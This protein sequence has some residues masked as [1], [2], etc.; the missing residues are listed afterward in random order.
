MPWKL[1]RLLLLVCG[2]LLAV[3]EPSSGQ[4]ANAEP[5]KVVMYATDWCPY[6]AKA[7]AHFRKHGIDYV[8]HDIEKSREGR[9]EYQRLGGRGVPLI[10]IG[11]Q[12]MS[13]FSEARFDSLYE[14][15]RR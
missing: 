11:E 7:R 3:A 2:V 1:A 10:L 8:E 13:G 6:C 14:S 9:A 5:Q 4:T 15:T 12:R